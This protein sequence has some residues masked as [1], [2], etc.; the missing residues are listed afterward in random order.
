MSGLDRPMREHD[1]LGFENITGTNWTNVKPPARWSRRVGLANAH[2]VPAT[3]S[4]LRSR[5]TASDHWHRG[6]GNPGRPHVLKSAETL[7]DDFFDEVERVLGERGIAI[8]AFDMEETRRSPVRR[9]SQPPAGR[10]VPAAP[11]AA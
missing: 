8:R 4:R 7:I 6:E 2:S 5:P 3:G 11:G 10:P 1:I 9:P